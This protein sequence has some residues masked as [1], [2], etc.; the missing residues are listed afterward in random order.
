M[1]PRDAARAR[2]SLGSDGHLL[3]SALAWSIG[4]KGVDGHM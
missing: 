1:A 2:L 4:G 3:A